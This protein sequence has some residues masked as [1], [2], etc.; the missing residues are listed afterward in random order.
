MWTLSAIG[1]GGMI[2]LA[3]DAI[4]AWRRARWRDFAALAGALLLATIAADW[5]L[6]P[7]IDRTRPFDAIPGVAVIGGRPHDAS[8]PSGHAAN[9]FAAALVLSAT[10]P[11]GRVV[12]WLLAA[13]IAYSRVYLGVHYPSDVV[14]GALVGAICGAIVAAARARLDNCADLYRPQR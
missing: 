2:W 13:A 7:L 10:A 9:A 3:I 11:R 6:K 4:I 5:I 1:R 8:F 12:W 14:G